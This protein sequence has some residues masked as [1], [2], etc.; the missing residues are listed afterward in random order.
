M[1]RCLPQEVGSSG[2]SSLNVW[3]KLWSLS[4]PPKIKH[5]GWRLIRNFLPA[6]ENL[7]HKGLHAC[8]FCN[9]AKKSSTHLFKVCFWTICIWFVSP[10]SIRIEYHYQSSIG[11]WSFAAEVSGKTIWNGPWYWCGLFG[12][13]GTSF[14]FY[15]FLRVSLRHQL[16][17]FLNLTQCFTGQLACSDQISSSSSLEGT[18]PGC[19]IRNSAGLVM[20][21]GSKRVTFFFL[22][23]NAEHFHNK[24]STYLITWQIVSCSVAH[25]KHEKKDTCPSLIGHQTEAQELHYIWT[26]FLMT[27]LQGFNKINKIFDIGACHMV[28]GHNSAIVQEA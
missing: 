11:E 18:G 5:F 13:Q 26:I 27:L 3:N 14:F 22:F 28:V 10:L 23:F 16:K 4:V 1:E 20:V 8:V 12:I 15:L 7:I 24:K 21:A 9:K 2:S 17:Q 19:V 6:R 25:P